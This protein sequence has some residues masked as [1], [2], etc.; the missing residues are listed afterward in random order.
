MS[1]PRPFQSFPKFEN[2]KTFE[3]L[4]EETGFSN[5]AKLEN[6]EHVEVHPTDGNEPPRG[7][8]T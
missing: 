3:A 7:G 4:G 6:F 5:F 1:R 8:G 2:F